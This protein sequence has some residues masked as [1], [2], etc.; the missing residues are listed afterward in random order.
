MNKALWF[1]DVETGLQF[2]P[3][4]T[5]LSSAVNKV[6]ALN[7]AS[8]RFYGFDVTLFHQHVVYSGSFMDLDSCN[9]FNDRM[10][11]TKFQMLVYVEQW[12]LRHLKLQ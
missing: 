1:H 7:G 11:H 12:G 3:R 8:V 10:I 5:N 6:L 2:I 4:K 9:G